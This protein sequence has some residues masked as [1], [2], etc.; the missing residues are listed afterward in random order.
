MVWKFLTTSFPRRCSPLAAGSYV[1]AVSSVIAVTLIMTVTS[2]LAIASVMNAL[3]V[4]D[5]PSV[6]AIA[7]LMTVT[8]VMAV[9]SV[10]AIAF[11]WA[12]TSHVIPVDPPSLPTPGAN[13][14]GY[15]YR[16]IVSTP[17]ACKISHP[18][19]IAF[20]IHWLFLHVYCWIDWS[21]GD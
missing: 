3:S 14:M 9:A 4:M 12:V 10:S 16:S 13:H 6:V 20:P 17:I 11:V 2:V 19:R 7:K 1:V 21:K 5:A 18:L 15:S 8:L